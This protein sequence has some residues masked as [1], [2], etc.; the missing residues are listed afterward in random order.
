MMIIVMI[1]IMMK[2]VLM[3]MMIVMIMMTMAMLMMIDR[4]RYSS[5]PVKHRQVLQMCTARKSE[6]ALDPKI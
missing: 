6:N 3:T 2:I 1:M 5:R 4:M